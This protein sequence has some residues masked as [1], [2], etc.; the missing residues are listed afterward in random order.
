MFSQLTPVTKNIIII[1]V[2][3][4]VGIFAGKCQYQR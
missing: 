1:N 4:F 3:F 2:I